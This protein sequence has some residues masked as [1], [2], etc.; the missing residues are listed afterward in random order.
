L[1]SGISQEYVDLIIRLLVTISQ[2]G[3]KRDFIIAVQAV[4]HY[5]QKS[6]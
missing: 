3:P 6:V 5:L 4:E 1:D 2:M